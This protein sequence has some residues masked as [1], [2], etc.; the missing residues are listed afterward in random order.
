MP[1][2]RFAKTG[3][4]FALA[5]LVLTGGSAARAGSIGL[6]WDPVPNATGY[7]VY[8]GPSQGNYTGSVNVGQV[9]QATVSTLTDCADWHLAVKAYNNNGESPTF[10]NEIVGWPRPALSSMKLGGGAAVQKV[11]ALQGTQAVLALTGKNFQFGA[12]LEIQNRAVAVDLDGNGQ[13]NVNDRLITVDSVTVSACDQLQAV[14]SVG[15]GANGLPAAEIGLWDVTVVNP[16]DH[17]GVEVYGTF[18]DKF[19]VTVDPSRFDI[20]QSSPA[21]AGRLD[22]KDTI[23]FASVFGLQETA[24]LFDPNSDFNGDGWTDGDDLSYL[25]NDMGKCWSNATKSW[26]EGACQ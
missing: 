13:V 14:V 21:T 23:W 1:G 7:K 17:D 6:S 16:T 10:S 15:P 11:V 24:G 3:G 25:A 8:Y 20:N 4:T 18:A 2:M 9:T 22:G 26:S 5:A 19:E 12:T